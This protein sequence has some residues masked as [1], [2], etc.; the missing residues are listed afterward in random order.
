MSVTMSKQSEITPRSALRHRPIGLEVDEFVVARTPRASRT[1]EQS[2]PIRVRTLK[3]QPRNEKAVPVLQS[4]ATHPSHF[5]LLVIALSMITTILL[6]WIAQNCWALGTTTLDDLRY[7]RPRTVH[8]DHF[9]GHETGSAPSHFVAMNINGQISILEIPGGNSGSSHLL[10]GPHLN[11][12]G[13]DL[14]PVTLD[15]VG[16]SH[17]PDLIAEV[18]GIAI[19]FHNTGKTFEATP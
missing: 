9:V 18:H 14:A 1:K 3:A 15:F 5:W 12:P 2:V 16:D 7:G 19:R 4:P 13:A 6:I 10:M 8:M 17:T 11:G